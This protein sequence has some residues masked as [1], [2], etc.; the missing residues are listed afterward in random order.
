[1]ADDRLVWRPLC[2]VGWQTNFAL[3]TVKDTLSTVA[4]MKG[5]HQA[6]KVEHK[7][8]KIDDIDVRAPPST[9]TREQASRLRQCGRGCRRGL[10]AC[11]MRESGGLMPA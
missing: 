9:Q 3:D 7:K 8:I 5:A 4:A 2:G 1:M 6:M 10:W 11:G